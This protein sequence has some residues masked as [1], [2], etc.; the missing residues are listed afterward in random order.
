MLVFP[1][2]RTGVRWQMRREGEQEGREKEEE[3]AAK[4]AQYAV[5]C[6][7]YHVGK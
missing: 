7:K 1:G 3:E 5:Q 4:V 2:A 6:T